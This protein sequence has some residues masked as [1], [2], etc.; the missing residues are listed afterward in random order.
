[1]DKEKLAKLL[2][3]LQA[4]HDLDDFD[5]IV[6]I[7]T[8][9]V[10]RYASY[11]ARNNHAAEDLTQKVFIV[12]W[13]NYAK[14]REPEKL[15]SWLRGTL[16]N[17]WRSPRA[18]RREIPFTVVFGD[19][20]PAGGTEENDL[21]ELLDESESLDRLRQDIQ[22]ALAGLCPRQRKSVDLRF[23]QGLTY[24]EMQARLGVKAS[25]LYSYVS[26][27]LLKFRGEGVLKKWR[28]PANEQ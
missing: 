9:Y 10:F 26:K 12:F 19:K 8:D 7:T 24:P 27:A 20:E 11:L 4:G 5:Q 25:T 2:R 22:S 13:R 3:R 16:Q 21:I 18:R 28:A 17:I 6:E 1:M 14:I 15:A 23:R